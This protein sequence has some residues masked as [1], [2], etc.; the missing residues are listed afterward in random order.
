M[1]IFLLFLVLTKRK[2]YLRRRHGH[3][4]R[5]APISLPDP[6]DGQHIT[7]LGFP[8]R[9]SSLPA[10]QPWPSFSACLSIEFLSLHRHQTFLFHHP[11]SP[12]SISPFRNL[13]SRF[14]LIRLHS[15]QHNLIN[16][17][18]RIIRIPLTPIITNRVRKNIPSPI[19]RRARYRPPHLRIPLQSMLRILIPEMKGAI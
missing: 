16:P 18:R 17:L 8:R 1:E 6:R 10:F 9:H 2:R 14:T 12:I 7:R 5:C 13:R 11:I 4:A 19:K 3:R 15:M